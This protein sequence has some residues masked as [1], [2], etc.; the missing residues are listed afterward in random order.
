MQCFC[1]MHSQWIYCEN[2]Y[3]V[4]DSWLYIPYCWRIWTLCAPVHTDTH[5]WGT[6]TTRYTS[7]SSLLHNCAPQSLHTGSSLGPESK[8]QFIGFENI[9]SDRRQGDGM[10][11]DQYYWELLCNTWNDDWLYMSSQAKIR[12]NCA[13]WRYKILILRNIRMKCLKYFRS[14]YVPCWS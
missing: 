3:N 2:Y 9:L 10:T 13:I 5:P 6:L 12:P 7:P 14:C 8:R 11:H 4:P 1:P